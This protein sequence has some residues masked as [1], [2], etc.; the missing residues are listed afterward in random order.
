MPEEVRFRTEEELKEEELERKIK[1]KDEDGYFLGG[2]VHQ[3]KPDADSGEKSGHLFIGNPYLEHPTIIRLDTRA[4]EEDVVAIRGEIIPMEESYQILEA[5]AVAYRLRQP[6]L[7]EGPTAVG[8]TFMMEK[9]TELLH[10]RGVRPLEFYCSGQTDVSELMAKWVPKTISE[11][12]KRH[13]EEFIGSARAQEKL[14]ETARKARNNRELSSEQKLA[15]VHREI[16]ELAKEAGLSAGTQWT[17]QYGAIPMAMGYTENL[18]GT[19]RC[20]ETGGAGFLLHIEEVGLAEPQVINVLLQLRGKRGKLAERIRLWEKG[21]DIEGGPRF[22][23][24]FSTNP[25]EEYLSRNE[26]DPALARGVV[27]K[28]VG[29]LSEDSLKMAARFY[30]TD[31]HKEKMGE[32]PEGCIL[33]FYEHPEICNQVSWLVA[34]FHMDLDKALKSG[35]KGRHQRIPLTLDDMYRVSEYLLHMQVRNRKNGFLDLAETLKRAINLY[36]LD[37]I[38]DVELKKDLEES[39]RQTLYGDLGKIRF[40]GRLTTRNEIL[41]TLIREAILSPEELEE[42]IKKEKEKEM[43]EFNQAKN[44]FNDSVREILENPR[45]PDTIRDELKS[46]MD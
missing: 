36:Y 16:Q 13:W 31:K 15:F 27:F 42:L 28:R 17:I 44:D 21:A 11:D 24:S 9:F 38:A 4:T 40:R 45:I 20:E 46:L 33:N 5:M 43:R 37:R 29:E 41:D 19:F 34:V 26:I 12:E 18:D 25:P 8:K 2:I 39:V 22:W 6:L 10:G 30:F 35:E 7:I 1:E 14:S 23:L 3:P 32:R